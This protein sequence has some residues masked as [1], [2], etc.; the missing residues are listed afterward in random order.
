MCLEEVEGLKEIMG[1][2]TSK[3]FRPDSIVRLNLNA[4]TP[5]RPLQKFLAHD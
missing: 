2:F 4:R 5:G 1:S 3:L